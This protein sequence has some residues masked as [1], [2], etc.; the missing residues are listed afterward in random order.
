MGRWR[1]GLRNQL[2]ALA[3]CKALGRHTFSFPFCLYV[4]LTWGSLKIPAWA[5]PRPTE[6]EPI[7]FMFLPKTFH[8]QK[9]THPKIFSPSFVLRLTCQTSRSLP[10][11][12]GAVLL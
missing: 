2:I 4:R 12:G 9:K 10:T 6:S 3:K 1:L 8:P 11:L 5:P 7:R